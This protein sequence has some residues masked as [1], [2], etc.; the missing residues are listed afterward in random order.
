MVNAFG[1]STAFLFL[2]ACAAA[3][4]VFAL[5]VPETRTWQPRQRLKPQAPARQRSGP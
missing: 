2:S 3:V 4:L 5:G 1:Y